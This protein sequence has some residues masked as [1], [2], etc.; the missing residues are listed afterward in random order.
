MYATMPMV[1]LAA[2]GRHV[3]IGRSSTA[4]RR[5]AERSEDRP[6]VEAY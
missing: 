4:A 2:A 1:G 3:P 6:P 5:I